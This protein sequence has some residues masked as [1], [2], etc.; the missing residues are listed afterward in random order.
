MNKLCDCVMLSIVPIIASIIFV[1]MQYPILY[2]WLFSFL[3]YLFIILD[4]ERKSRYDIIWSFW[5]AYIFIILPISII[6]FDL[7]G[8]VMIILISYFFIV[9]Y[10]QRKEK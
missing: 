5:F 10:Y 8:K 1:Y 2:I 7:L 9:V 3:S 6:N 4:K